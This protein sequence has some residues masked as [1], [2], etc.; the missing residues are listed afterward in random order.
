MTV[1][2]RLPTEGGEP[3]RGPLAAHNSNVSAWIEKIAI[4]DIHVVGRHRDLDP[5]MLRVIIKSLALVG[6]Q[7]PITVRRVEKLR[8]EVNPTAIELVLGRYRFEAAKALGWDF[9]DAFVIGVDETEARIQ[10]LIEN[11]CRAELTALERA[12]AV[13]ELVDLVR[14]RDEAGQLAHPRG[15]QPHDRGISWASRVL[16]FTR[17]EIRRSK[18]IASISAEAKSKAKEHGLDENQSALLEIA[19]EDAADGQLAK[20]E[21][22]AIRNIATRARLRKRR[23]DTKPHKK[24]KATSKQAESKA[25]AS[26]E[27]AESEALPAT[28]SPATMPEAASDDEV[29]RLKAELADK[30]KRL[31]LA[32]EALRQ[33]RL[34]SSRASHDVA[35]PGPAT[36]PGQLAGTTSKSRSLSLGVPLTPEEE[37]TLAALMTA[38]ANAHELKALFAA[39]SAIV[40]ERFR[41]TILRTVEDAHDGSLVGLLI[42]LRAFEST[43]RA[44]T[45]ARESSGIVHGGERI[46]EIG[47]E[48]AYY[49]RS[50]LCEM[51]EHTGP[52]LRETFAPILYVLRYSQLDDAIQMHN[53]VGA[54]LTSSIFTLDVREA[55]RFVSTTGSDCGIANVNIGPSGAEIGGAFGGEKETGGGREAGSDAWKAYMRRATNT[56]NFGTQLPLAQGVRFDIEG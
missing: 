45:E 18:T 36:A 46:E 7:N 16:G 48:K 35:I 28:D 15:R 1:K 3:E 4:A 12:E 24:S 9:I 52:V 33:A 5:A 41:A 13:T 25:S 30:G 21:E 2:T 47:G 11:L 50:A 8:A 32:E 53:A 39:A 17:E 56:I 54:G 43:Q 44:L 20:I 23:G 10:Q 6:L 37:G 27:P 38:W 22:I 40:R 29:E 26:D 14:Q 42:D 34:A 19:T 49:V 31:E 51:P 55:E